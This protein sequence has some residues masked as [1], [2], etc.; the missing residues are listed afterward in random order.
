MQFFPASSRSLGEKNEA[1]VELRPSFTEDG[2]YELIIQSEDATGNQSG[3]VDYKVA[4]EVINK[5]AISRV[6]NYPN[7]F[8]NSTQFVYTLTG[9]QTPDYF[10]IQIMTVAGKIVREITQDEIGPLKIGTRVTGIQWDGT[11]EY[12]GRLA[13]GVYLYRVVAK[14]ANGLNFDRHET[15]T[16]QFFTKDFGKMVIMR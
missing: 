7:P 10:K 12:G 3:D 6:L 15:N 16:S 14:D 2:T 9:N 4:F 8:S 1:Y 13:N 11:D 5:Q